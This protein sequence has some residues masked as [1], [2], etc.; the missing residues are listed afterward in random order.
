MSGGKNSFGTGGYYQ[1][2][3]EA[4]LPVSLELRSEH[5]KLALALMIVMDRS[6]SMAA[7]AR[8]DRTKMDLA[9]IAAA[10]VLDMLSPLDEFGVMA[11][12]TEAHVVVPLQAAKDKT[13]WRDLILRIESMGGGIYVY[14]GLARAA[15][16]LLQAKPQTRHII[17]FSDASDSEQPGRYWELLEKAGKAGMTV[18]VIGLGTEEDSDANLL[19]KIAAAGNGRIFF[20][21]DP[22]ELP[23]LFA[24][25]TFV[26]ARSTFIE[27]P[28][29]IKTLAGIDQ[30]GGGKSGIISS[31]SSYNLC[32]LKNDAVQGACTD[33]ENKAPLIAAWQY[34][35]GKVV[36]YTGIIDPAV[37]GDFVRSA[38]A[39]DILAGISNWISSDHRQSIDD[40]PLTQKIENGR[41]KVTMHLDPERERELFRENP[42]AAV[43]RSRNDR[44]PEMEKTG[45]NWDTADSLTAELPLKADETIVAMIE[46]K[47]GRTRLYPI[48]LP[49]SHEVIPQTGNAGAETLKKIAGIS[50]G[51]EIIDLSGIWKS[52]PVKVRYQPLV[53]WLLTFAVL[54]F[55][56][57]IAERR[58]GLS[59][60]LFKMMRRNNSTPAL[61]ADNGVPQSER[62]VADHFAV[63]SVPLEENDSPKKD[64]ADDSGFSAAL[65]QAKRQADK[66][67]R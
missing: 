60:V 26:A 61:A 20:T 50:G 57:E 13:R 42:S 15:E 33:D 32:Y 59:A 36:C 5:R 41:W 4:A 18:S 47:S 7:P 58:T 2:P 52:L 37:G 55:I 54:L 63:A 25:D 46:A 53:G 66:I 65:K 49:Y 16:M 28:A 12:D 31:V 43:I 44:P 11:V 21:R 30:F 6:G 29:P 8:G 19:K 24:Q 62:L 64:S 35:L 23:R 40:M 48:C 39:A 34:G 10:S 27:D 3:L 56:L 14:E 67:S 9:N 38:A 17:L 22:E 1:S 45:M 51:K